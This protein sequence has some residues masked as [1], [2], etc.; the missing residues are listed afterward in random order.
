MMNYQKFST[1]CV[2]SANPRWNTSLQFQIHDLHRDILSVC[3]Y[4]RKLYSPN[5]FLGKV[6]LKIHQIF[7]EQMKDNQENEPITRVFRMSNVPTGKI[8]LKMSLSIYKKQ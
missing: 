4:D 5:V 7:R 6:E 3:V 8:M 1:H 2:E